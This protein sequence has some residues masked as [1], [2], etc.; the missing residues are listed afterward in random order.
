M[1]RNAGNHHLAQ[2][3][4]K[5]EI[6]QTLLLILIILLVRI[7]YLHVHMMVQD[8]MQCNLLVIYIQV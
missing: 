7:I 2:V 1:V 6:V 5:I 4:V 8:V 3:I